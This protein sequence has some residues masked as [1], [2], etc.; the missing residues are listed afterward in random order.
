MN[1]TYLCFGLCFFCSFR[2][3]GGVKDGESKKEI[4]RREGHD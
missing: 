1:C 4:R 2:V 3:V